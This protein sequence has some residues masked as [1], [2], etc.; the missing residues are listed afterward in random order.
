MNNNQN[1]QSEEWRRCQYPLVRHEVSNFGRIRHALTKKLL[2]PAISN[3]G[4]KHFTARVK[5]KTVNASVHEQV[6]LAFVDGWR[7]GLQVNHKDGNK[8]NNCAWNLEWIT[9]SENVRHSRYVLGKQVKP[10]VL[11]NEKGFPEHVFRSARECERIL[12]GNV[13]WEIKRGHRYHGF[14][15]LYITWAQYK[16]LHH[17]VSVHVYTLRSAWVELQTDLF[18]NN[19]QEKP[20]PNPPQRGRG[21]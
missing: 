10:V 9:A 7:E 12:R 11:L 3:A 6:A 13:R 21:A 1:Q 20:H 17:L 16:M 5:G 18:L 2:R 4:Y 14:R 19:Q 8:L 15:P